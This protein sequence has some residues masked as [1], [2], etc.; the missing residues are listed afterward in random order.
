MRII[1]GL[2]KYGVVIH[3][4]NGRSER[5]ILTATPAAF[6]TGLLGEES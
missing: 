5:L 6:V 3:D 2:P 4:M 1:E